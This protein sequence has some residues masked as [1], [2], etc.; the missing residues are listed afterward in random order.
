MTWP[1]AKV[2]GAFAGAYLLLQGRVAAA[3]GDLADRL[4]CRPLVQPR[5]AIILPFVPK[6]NL[7][8]A[9]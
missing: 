4:A 5:Q 6:P 8:R 3:N 7:Q 2:G 9:A 1:A